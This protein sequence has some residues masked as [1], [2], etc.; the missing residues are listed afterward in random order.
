MTTIDTQQS[1]LLTGV[2][3]F[4]E[5]RRAE[6]AWRRAVRA[7][8]LDRYREEGLPTTRDEEWRYTPVTSISD[9]NPPL[10]TGIE[11]TSADIEPFRFAEFDGP[12]LV[13]VDGRLSPALSVTRALPAGARVTTIAEL[14]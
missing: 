9:A 14:L 2:D 7:R 13:F 4:V 1:V 11:A 3:E 6:P 10:A 8:A 12:Q 5:A